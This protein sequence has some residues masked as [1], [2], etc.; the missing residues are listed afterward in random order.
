MINTVLLEKAI[1]DSGLKKKYIAKELGMSSRSFSK[2]SKGNSDFTGE[3]ITQLC[4]IL[5]ISDNN[6]KTDIFLS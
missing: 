1:S 6:Q 2:K 3:Q 4:D 5:S